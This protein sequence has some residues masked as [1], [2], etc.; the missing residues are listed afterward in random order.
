[1]TIDYIINSFKRRNDGSIFTRTQGNNI[2]N[3]DPITYLNNGEHKRLRD[4]ICDDNFVINSVSKT[5][6]PNDFYTLGTIVYMLNGFIGYSIE[7]IIIKDGQ[8]CL[9]FTNDTSIIKLNDVKKTPTEMPKV[10]EKKEAVKK[11]ATSTKDKDPFHVIENKILTSFDG[12]EIRL[13]KTLKKRKET[14][15]EFFTKYFVEWNQSNSDKA[16]CTI[17]DDNSEIQTTVGKRRSLGDIYMLAKYY[18]P[19]TTLKDVIHML[20]VD[21]VNLEHF[22]T[23]YCHTINKR[24][25]Y[26]GTSPNG[27]YDTEKADEYGHKWEYYINTLNK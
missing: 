20:Y 27:Q 4:F 5:N 8:I 2:H 16:K 3:T 11:L 13:Q 26:I 9:K 14:M 18:Y 7:K 19:K 12:R 22:R 1:M 25:W 6:L 15:I 10:I 17:W 23:S 21:M 24:V